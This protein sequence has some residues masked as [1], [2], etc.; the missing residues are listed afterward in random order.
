MAVAKVAA[1]IEGEAIELSVGYE[2]F[3]SGRPWILTPGGGHFSRQYPGVRELAQAL[4]DLGNRVIIWDKPNTGE[5]DLCIAGSSVA[6]VQADFC[7]GLLRTLGV[8]PAFV[9]GGSAGSRVSMLTA[10]RHREAVRGIGLWWLTGG[11]FG[12]LAIAYSQYGPA[13]EAAWNGGMEAVAKLPQWQEVLTSNL[14]NRER[15][16]AQDPKRFVDTLQSWML[17]MAPGDEL[18]VGMPNAE[19]RKVVDCPALIFKSGFSDMF[20]PRSASDELAALL[21]NVRYVDPPWPDTEWIDGEPRTLFR[22]WPK[23][24]PILHEWA[25]EAVG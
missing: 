21:P 3:G 17:A 23:L 24:A 1:E 20:H 19:V 7:A 6:N 10:V 14:G 2:M 13:V 22:S 5:T 4:A 25:N 18:V 11:T 12:R 15:L 9:I 16:L 8:A